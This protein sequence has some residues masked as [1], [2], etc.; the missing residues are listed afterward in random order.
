LD[1]GFQSFNI[2]FDFPFFGQ[3]YRTV[4]VGSNGY[5][6]FGAGSSSFQTYHLP[7]QS[8]PASMIAALESDLN[9][10]ASGDVYYQEE[11]D[12]VIVQFSNVARY[13]GDGFATFQI[14]LQRDG[15]ILLYY[16][17]VSGNA[18]FST[19]GMQDSTRTT[20]I[21]VA[22]TQPYLKNN[23][24]I[25]LAAS[26][27][28]LSISPPSGTVP[29]DGAA[30]INL[31]FDAQSL[32]TA[33][34]GATIRVTALSAPEQVIDIP[35]AM[36]INSGPD[37]A[38]T[39]AVGSGEYIE[40]GNLTV[41]AAANDADGIAKVE[42]FDED[43]FGQTTKFGEA[44][45][46]PYTAVLVGMSGGSHTIV[47]RA[48]DT[49]GAVSS[50][51]PFNIYIQPDSDHDGLGDDWEFRVFGNLDQG[52][53]DDPDGDGFSN[54]AE[55]HKDTNLTQFNDPTD[56]DGDGKTDEEEMALGTDPHV[57]NLFFETPYSGFSETP[58]DSQPVPWTFYTQQLAD[59]RAEWNG[60]SLKAFIKFK[61][62]GTAYN[63]VVDDFA[64]VN[65]HEFVRLLSQL[66]YDISSYWNTSGANTFTA[67]SDIRGGA[68][69]APFQS[70]LSVELPVEIVPD[71]GVEG[72]LGGMMP[73]VLGEEGENH[74][75]GPALLPE[76]IPND[77]YVT[78]VAQGIDASVFQRLLQWEGGEDVPGEPL[79]RR[80]SRNAALK[81]ELR[82]LSKTNNVEVAKV[83]VWIV[84]AT[85]AIINDR[86]PTTRFNHD[87]AVPAIDG[88]QGAGASITLDQFYRFRFSIQPGSITDGTADVPNLTGGK[89]SNG[90]NQLGDRSSTSGVPL[91]NGAAARWDVSRRV[92][93]HL[94]NP[95]LIP[96][97]KMAAG[98]GLLYQGE[99]QFDLVT[100]N[101]PASW[102][103]G[104]D[105]TGVQD[106][107]NNPYAISDRVEREH[108][109][110][111]ISSLDGPNL[112]IPDSGGQEG[113]T[114]QEQDLFQEFAR[115]QIGGTWYLIA[116]PVS[117][118]VT[119][120]V[121]YHSGQWNDN[122]SE[123]GSGN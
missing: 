23:L 43:D 100:V 99:P 37:V 111:E 30:A 8:A 28:W 12:K 95:N 34:Y 106:E 78:F 33:T 113:F 42:F 4:Y 72:V 2:S 10:R 52:A 114:F 75:V 40:G 1:D 45:A 85:G 48:T 98:F 103:I 84:S 102:V 68:F 46:P 36:R 24:A 51:G 17:D 112:R 61:S 16:Q 108:S 58:H 29:A 110:G 44:V 35:V 41:D 53:S 21:T 115:V 120:K 117:W 25:R 96:Y 26:T 38:I 49:F 47:A 79:K 70:V 60:L 86:M 13:S 88:T 101:F 76:Q 19:V 56:S 9:L 123:T 71:A 118:H 119:M 97:G 39:S 109:I 20:G 14:V 81:T 27:R 74:F 5:I 50:S 57:F 22:V 65:G 64:S 6:T 82:I 93:Y 77:Q 31:A 7:N 105:D 121:V 63:W 80:I 87:A 83:N 62:A 69:C 59:A 90:D 94:L 3:T 89:D 122:G 107:D 116:E 104:N 67:T 73:S 18:S 15:G 91:A 92:Q 54:L 55:F 32:P 66:T 11:A